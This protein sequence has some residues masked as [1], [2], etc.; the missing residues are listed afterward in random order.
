M[1]SR[2]FSGTAS[3]VRLIAD[4]ESLTDVLWSFQFVDKGDSVILERDAAAL[5][6]GQQRVSP[7]PEFAG[8]VTG[9]KFRG[10][11]QKGPIEG[12]G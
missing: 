11:A 4:G 7:E 8:S 10:G 3:S 9:D 6:I 1:T 12:H 2:C 5:V